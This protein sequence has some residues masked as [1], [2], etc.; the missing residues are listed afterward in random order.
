MKVLIYFENEKAIKKSGIGRAFTHQKIALKKANVEYTTNPKDS[1]DLAHI[2][3]VFRKSYKLLK[4]IN[5]KNIPVIVHAHSSKED[6]LNSFRL[7]N[8]IAPWFNSRLMKM[9]RN[10]KTIIAP[11]T[12]TK[13]LVGSY[14]GVTAQIYPISNG[15]DLETYLLKH[16][17]NDMEFEDFKKEY[18]VADNQKFIIC[19]GLCFVRKGLLDF[20]E[21]AKMFPDIKFIWFGQHYKIISS[22]TVLKAIRKAPSNVLFPGYVDFK[23]IKVAMSKASLFF[24]PSYEENEGIVVLEALASKLPLL[25]RDIPVYKDWLTDGLNCYKAKN[26]TEFA[27]K[28]KI[29]I[30]NDNTKLVT[31]GYEVVQKR[32]LDIIGNELKDVYEKVIKKN[33]ESS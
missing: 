31:S 13:N 11:T 27:D 16:Q 18:N 21:V 8:V 17:T 15:I 4:K 1:Y 28:I 9:Y 33:Q 7:S 2:N 29:I 26:N 14:K 5:K 10:T 24:F 12:Y 25:I 20:C 3:T 19:I 6:F 22:S 23:Y 30:N 32:T